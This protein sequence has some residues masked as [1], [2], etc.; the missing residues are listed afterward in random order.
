MCD[1]SK[2]KSLQHPSLYSSWRLEW[3]KRESLMRSGEELKG[4]QEEMDCEW[5][6]SETSSHPEE[7]IEWIDSGRISLLF[8]LMFVPR[9]WV[10]FHSKWTSF[11][12]CC[13][14]RMKR[15]IIVCASDLFSSIRIIAVHLLLYFSL[16]FMALSLSSFCI[17]RDWMI[18][19]QFDRRLSYLTGSIL[20]LQIVFTHCI[21]HIHRILSL[22]SQP[23]WTIYQWGNTIIHTEIS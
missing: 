4:C 12:L 19:W 9:F 17:K 1:Q 21:T 20:W 18:D 14:L 23:P 22:N 15:K 5:V 7:S 13:L 11:L 10:T 2:S 16:F 3:Y 6:T 8:W